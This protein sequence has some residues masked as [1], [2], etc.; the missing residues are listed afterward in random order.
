M[1]TK[2]APPPTDK[3]A[4]Q[5]ERVLIYRDVNAITRTLAD[6]NATCR[7][8]ND[9]IQ[10]LTDRELLPLGLTDEIVREMCFYDCRAIADA[11][12]KV[13]EAEPKTTRSERRN[14][15]KL[16]E[17]EIMEIHELILQLAN[18]MQT[19]KL[20]DGLTLTPH[21]RSVY[22]SA[23]N[24][25][26]SFRRADVVEYYSRYLDGEAAKAYADEAR[27]VFDTL[28]DF[29]RKTRILSNNTVR[30][31]GDAD[32]GAIPEIIAIYDGKIHLDFNAISDL[33]FEG[34]EERARRME[35]NNYEI[36]KPE[37]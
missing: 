23:T 2:T 11:L 16:I 6:L 3:G 13:E 24:G 18:T 4:Q 27:R 28:V 33:D 20:K 34:A 9:T 19:S 1:R 22:L 31:V 32:P 26:V 5:P 7:H 12:E 37:R 15:A 29:D 10:Q 14:A 17:A 25:K 30:G 36:V 21:E 8:F 35:I